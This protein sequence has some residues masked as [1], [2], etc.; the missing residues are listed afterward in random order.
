MPN[1]RETVSKASANKTSASAF[2]ADI[3]RGMLH[4]AQTTLGLLFM[5]TVM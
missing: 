4:M 1:T 3:T 5:L 2:A